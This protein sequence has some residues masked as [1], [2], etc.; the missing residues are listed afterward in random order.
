MFTNPLY[1][2]YSYMKDDQYSYNYWREDYR[3][4]LLSGIVCVFLLEKRVGGKNTI[5]VLSFLHFRSWKS[6]LKRIFEINI[7]PALEALIGSS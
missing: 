3:K 7:P 6:E 1:D 2:L 5:N 4:T